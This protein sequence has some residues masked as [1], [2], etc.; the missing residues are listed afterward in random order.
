MRLAAK[1]IVA[2]MRGKYPFLCKGGV[3]HLCF[4]F[5]PFHKTDICMSFMSRKTKCVRM[6]GEGGRWN[7]C[8]FVLPPPRL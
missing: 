8:L 3:D 2:N 6:T 1:V 7:D 4:P 5:L